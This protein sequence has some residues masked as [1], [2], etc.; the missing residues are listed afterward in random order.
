MAEEVL[1]QTVDGSGATAPITLHVEA[2]F[3]RVTISA[4]NGVGTVGTVTGGDLLEALTEL[5]RH[6]E[7]RH[8]L[9]CCQGARINVWPSGL[10]RQFSEGRCGYVLGARLEDGSFEVV[11]L[12]APAPPV[13]A[14][15]VAQQQ[16]FVRAFHG[17]T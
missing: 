2:T 17:L 5:R 13:Q 3:S 7:D 8:L 12:L 1:L 10:L 15:N 9:L 6:L 16:E 11:D 4:T 14:A